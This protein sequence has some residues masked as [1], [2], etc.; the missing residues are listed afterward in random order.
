MPEFIGIRKI[1]RSKTTTADIS[2]LTREKYN[3]AVDELLY[4]LRPTPGKSL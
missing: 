2:L 4:I 3:R 1:F